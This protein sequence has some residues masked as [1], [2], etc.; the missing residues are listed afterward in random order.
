MYDV[1]PSCVFYIVPNFKIP[2]LFNCTSL[3][4]VC[5]HIAQMSCVVNAVSSRLCVVLPLLSSMFGLAAALRW[6]PCFP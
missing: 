4:S 5:I 2:I 3:Y 1:H 6:L